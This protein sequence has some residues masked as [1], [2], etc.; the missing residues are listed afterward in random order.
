[1]QSFSPQSIHLRKSGTLERPRPRSSNENYSDAVVGARAASVSGYMHVHIPRSAKR[2]Y[3]VR[4]GYR[5]PGPGTRS[6]GIGEERQCVCV[7]ARAR[8][9]CACVRVDLDFTEKQQKKSI[10]VLCIMQIP[11]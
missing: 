3:A 2:R 11:L 9:V 7:C 8:S 5:V 4:G 1:M 6:G 10:N